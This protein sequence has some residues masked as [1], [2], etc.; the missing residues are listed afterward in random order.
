MN[1]PKIFWEDTKMPLCGFNKQMLEGLKQFHLGLVEHGIVERSKTKGQSIEETIQNELQDMKRFQKELSG[2]EDSFT[3][4]LVR[5]LTEYSS[6]FYQLINNKGIEN[7]KTIVEQI[8]K[9]Y[10]EMDNKYYSELE[11]KSNDMGQL[12][13]YLNKI[14]IGRKK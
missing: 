5:N 12:V 1:L 2:I 8:D 4:E 9:L 6:S 13:Q 3:R 11:G 10:F 14:N 7:Y